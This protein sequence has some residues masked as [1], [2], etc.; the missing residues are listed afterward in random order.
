MLANST[1]SAI[2]DRRSNPGTL[3]KDNVA[4]L[5]AA[6]AAVST[7]VFGVPLATVMDR[8]K[9]SHPELKVPNFV[10]I[11]I[12]YIIHR[13]IATE[14]LFRL[15]GTKGVIEDLKNHID[16]GEEPKFTAVED[17]HNISGL[18]KMYLREL[19]QPLLSSDHFQEILNI[20]DFP[21]E[22]HALQ[23]RKIIQQLPSTI[24]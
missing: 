8:Q 12:G 22:L 5:A 24:R 3:S 10:H 4:A 19:P 23:L 9:I 2:K 11:A 16:E 7:K 18:L 15:S 14:G 1:S 21:P 20:A 6:Q 13:G 17:L